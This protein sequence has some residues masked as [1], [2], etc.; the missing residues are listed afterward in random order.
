MKFTQPTFSGCQ[1]PD[2]FFISDVTNTTSSSVGNTD[3]EQLFKRALTSVGLNSPSHFK[4]FGDCISSMSNG[5]VMTVSEDTFEKALNDYAQYYQLIDKK[6]Y[7]IVHKITRSQAESITRA[8]QQ[9][10]MNL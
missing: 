6:A 9:L 7:F 8:F 2:I 3:M 10:L 5:S 1:Y 4:S